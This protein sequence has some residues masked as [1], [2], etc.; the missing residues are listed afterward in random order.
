MKVGSAYKLVAGA[1]LTVLLVPHAIRAQQTKEKVTVDDVDRNFVVRLPK[2]Y[3]A[4]QHYPVV[5]LLHGLNQDAD[6]MQRLTRFDETADKDGVISVYPI[7]LHGR[8]NIGVRPQER[9]P[10]G[11][12]PGRRGRYGGGYPGGGYPGG[13]G[14]YPRGGGQQDPNQ[15][16]NQNRA[17]TPAD[18]KNKNRK[19]Q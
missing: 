19:S 17:P 10:S 12:G 11:M 8:W 2:G 1:C 4:Q 13:G 5:I 7:A 3:D 14:G 16:P 9:R 15:Q 6:D 18:E